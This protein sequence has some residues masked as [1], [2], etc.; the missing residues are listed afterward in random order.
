[1]LR[2]VPR[3]DLNKRWLRLEAMRCRPVP[4]LHLQAEVLHLLRQPVALSAPPHRSARRL[5]M[6]LHLVA[7]LR[8]WGL[9]LVVVGVLYFHHLNLQIITQVLVV[10]RARLASQVRLVLE[11]GQRLAVLLLLEVVL[12]LNN[13]LQVVVLVDSNL[14]VVLVLVVS[15]DNHREGL[16]LILLALLREN[17]KCGSVCFEDNSKM[18]CIVH[19][20]VIVSVEF[21]EVPTTS[22]VVVAFRLVKML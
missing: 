20:L 14:P 19:S 1:M 21:Y 5:L 18:V 12:V 17:C 13:L 15:L 10:N 4:P 11:V 6:V 8:T 2:Q 22:R 3:S 9:V 7:T 16:C